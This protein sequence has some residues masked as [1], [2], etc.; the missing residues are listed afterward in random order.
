MNRQGKNNPMFGRKHKKTTIEELRAQKLGD[1]NPQW[2]G[3]NVGYFGVH[4]WI[5]N[6]LPKPDKCEICNEQPAF[7]LANISGEYRRNLDDWQWICRRCHML[8]DGRLNNLRHDYKRITMNCLFCGREFKVIPSK[9]RGR[10]FC[11]VSC[12]VKWRWQFGRCDS[13]RKIERDKALE[14]YVRANPHLSLKEIGKVFGISVSRVWQIRKAK[15]DV[16]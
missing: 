2:K 13:L 7:D 12:A 5:K 6:R 1:K 11:S 3:D 10:T 8:Q 15:T 14:D 9:S 16:L 4:G